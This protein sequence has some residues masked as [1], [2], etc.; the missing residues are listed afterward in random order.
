[1]RNLFKKQCSKK[2]FPTKVKH[3]TISTDFSYALKIK[4]HK[5]NVDALL[6][7]NQSS[8]GYVTCVEARTKRINK[9]QKSYFF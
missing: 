9:K 4:Q 1:V 5:L 3:I 2:R 7:L 6:K 8:D